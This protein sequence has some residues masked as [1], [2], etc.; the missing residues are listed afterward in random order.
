MQGIC[1]VLSLQP[2]E[3]EVLMKIALSTCC[4]K[5]VVAHYLFNILS[6]KLTEGNL[7][8]MYVGFCYLDSGKLTGEFR[9]DAC[10][11][12]LAGQYLRNE[13]FP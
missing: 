5:L 1:T 11:I 9:S 10:W 6:G 2:Q 12:L 4:L 3:C 8:V 7:A 13:S